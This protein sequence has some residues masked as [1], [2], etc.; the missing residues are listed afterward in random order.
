MESNMLFLP[1]KKAADNT[2]FVKISFLSVELEAS[3]V[4]S[5]G[6]T[7]YTVPKDAL[8]WDKWFG[9]VVAADG[10]IKEVPI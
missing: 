10:E 1:Y 7:V 9:V 4:S 2:T 3:T 5:E 6:Q 8:E